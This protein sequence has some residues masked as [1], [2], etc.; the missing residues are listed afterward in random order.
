LEEELQDLC[1]Q[2][3]VNQAVE[4]ALRGYGPEIRRLMMGVLQNEDRA[5]DAF[6]LFSEFLLKGLPGFRWESSFRTWAQRMA[7]NA[8]FKLVNA[9]AIRHR[10]VSLSAVPEQPMARHST[11]CPWQRTPVKARF[12]A[13]REKLEPQ[14][15][16]LLELRVDQQL[17]WPQIV[18]LLAASNEPVTGELLARRATALRQQF[19]RVKNRMRTLARQE[20]VIAPDGTCA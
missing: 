13:L 11:T 18:Q 4:Q 20:G 19:Q 3:E 8:C 2:G 1:R 10:H 14:E 5:Q 17:Q 12:R 6:S 16:R 7:R 15:Q 9:P